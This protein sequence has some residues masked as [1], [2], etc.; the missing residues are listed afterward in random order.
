M[1]RAPRKCANGGFTLIE[2]LMVA[3][4]IGILISLLLPVLAKAKLRAVQSKCGSNLRQAGLA[5]RMFAD[6][7]DSRLPMQISLRKGGSLEYVNQGQ[8]WRHFQPISNLLGRA[9]LL[10]CPGDRMRFATNWN[11]LN[12]SNLSYFIGVDAEMRSPNT[13]LSGDRNLFVPGFTPP[14][15]IPVRADSPAYWTEEM[16][17]YRGNILFVDGRVEAVDSEGLQR[18]FGQQTIKPNH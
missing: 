17:Q 13:L 2:L 15:T 18:T 8:P 12:S 7:H 3:A 6:E 14:G 9:D 1:K 10:V 5:F 4:V 11:S 16:H